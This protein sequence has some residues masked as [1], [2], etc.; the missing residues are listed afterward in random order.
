MLTIVVLL[1]AGGIVPQLNIASRHHAAEEL[2]RQRSPA[3]QAYDRGQASG[4]WWQ[5]PQAPADGQ[6]EHVERPTATHR[7]AGAT[8]ARIPARLTPRPAAVERD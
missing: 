8:M 6:G 4:Q 2:L 7:S 3:L 1:L 5:S